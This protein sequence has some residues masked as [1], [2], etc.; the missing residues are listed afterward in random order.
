MHIL[1]IKMN[2][3]WLTFINDIHYPRTG[4]S[5]RHIVSGND[6]D[7]CLAYITE[8]LLKHKINPFCVDIGVDEG[9]WSFFVVD[10]NTSAKV[11]S[12]EPN[13]DSYP[14]LLPYTKNEP[15]IELHNIAISDK[16]GFI[17][18]S[19]AG[20]SSHSRDASSSLQVECKLIAPFI[21][22][23]T[24][25]IMKID[26]EGHELHILPTLYP[27]LPKIETL[28]FEVST[29]WYNNDE[30]YMEVFKHLFTIYPF[31]YYMS[32]NGPPQVTRLTIEMIIDLKDNSKNLQ[33]DVCCTQV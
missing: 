2:F 20:C 28:I 21:E 1:V 16:N 29:H 6:G 8:G 23:K 15:R 25:D 32:R 26:T 19:L 33:W 14:R 13:P 18:F 24:I 12:F 17:P 5:V 7:V 3:P 11:L 4:V 30:K 10:T 22:G 27:F 9:W 31:I